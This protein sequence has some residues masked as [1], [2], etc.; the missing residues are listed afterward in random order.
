MQIRH[1]E[2]GFVLKYQSVVAFIT[3]GE[4][5]WSQL[6]HQSKLEVSTD[7]PTLG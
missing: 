4:K 7:L 1:I 5:T 3:N 6:L 2:K